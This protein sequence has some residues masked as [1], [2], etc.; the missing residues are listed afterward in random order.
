MCKRL[1]WYRRFIII[2]LA[3][4]IVTVC[5]GFLHAEELNGMTTSSA[6]SFEEVPAYSGTA[7]VTVHGN[8]PDFSISEI[9]TDPYV[10]FSPLDS[11]GRTG[12]GMACLGQETLPVQARGEIGEIYPSGWQTIRYDDLI[13]D[14]YLYNRSHVI[15]YQLC[16][17]NATPE[18]LFTGT[19]YLNSESMLFFEDKIS[20]Y[21]NQ[22]TNNHVLY[23]VTP[24]YKENDLVATGVQME[25][26]S[27]ED[28]G[29]G[30]CFNVF[31]YNIQPGVQIDYATGESW[32]DPAYD[33]SAI[34]SAAQAMG[35][36]AG[37][38]FQ[39]IPDGQSTATE[40]T[41]TA[42]QEELPFV[43]EEADPSN[44]V[45]YVLNTNTK[46]FHYPYCSSVDEMKEK[47]KQ[48]FE[49]SRDEAVAMGYVPCK[50]CNP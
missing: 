27:V 48:Y 21:L 8:I 47:N 26:Y 46:K 43:M 39:I 33:P 25:A 42:P 32:L 20:F 38:S 49:G 34:V 41:R 31:A 15:G 1:R 17:D 29:S 16:G 5:P 19:R 37:T 30:V 22:S 13:D 10:A 11:L 3:M 35:I 6:L 40:M 18:N 9:T 24:V 23:R 2:V 45:T 14:R 36:T 4:F 28:Q 44:T 50:R 12:M 7:F